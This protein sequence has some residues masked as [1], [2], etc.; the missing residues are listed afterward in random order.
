MSGSKPANEDVQEFVGSLKTFSNQLS[1]MQQAMLGRILDAA[2]LDGTAG[3]GKQY[4]RSETDQAAGEDET[5]GYARRPPR[6]EPPIQGDG[7][8][9]ERLAAWLSREDETSGYQAK[10]KF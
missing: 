5:A 6:S 9:W 1:P 7:G 4:G 10:Y 2:S 8:R 3:Y